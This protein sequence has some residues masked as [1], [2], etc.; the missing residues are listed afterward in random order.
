MKGIQTIAY[1]VAVNVLSLLVKFCLG[2]FEMKNL[3][4]V[5]KTVI[6]SFVVPSF[7]WHSSEGL[8]IIKLCEFFQLSL[9][10]VISY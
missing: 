4:F 1:I 5:L 8:V 9:C 7:G 10:H 3:Q 6:F 2:I